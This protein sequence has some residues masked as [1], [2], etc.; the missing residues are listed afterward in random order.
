[1]KTAQPPARQSRLDPK[2]REIRAGWSPSERRRRADW[3]RRRS[4]T[5]I[6]L[7][8]K[9][10]EPEEIWAVGAPVWDDAQRLGSET[11]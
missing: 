6:R 2:L 7:I 11:A 1:M 3:G 5:F 9:K 4:A 8:S 10:A